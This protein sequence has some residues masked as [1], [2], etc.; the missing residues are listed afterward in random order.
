MLLFSASHLC[1][2]LCRNTSWLARV[3]SQ[4]KL[5]VYCSIARVLGNLYCFSCMALN[6]D[7][8]NYSKPAD[9]QVLNSTLPFLP[10]CW[11]HFYLF[12]FFD[13]DSEWFVGYVLFPT[14]KLSSEP[15]LLC[16][17][18]WRGSTYQLP[19]LENWFSELLVLFI[20]NFYF[21]RALISL[22]RIWLLCILYWLNAVSSS[23][24]WKLLL[25]SMPMI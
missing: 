24:S 1:I 17:L 23:Q 20:Y 16:Y 7:S 19:L 8:D 3:A 13:Q 11:K 21:F 10:L 18:W 22:T 9:F 4:I 5:Q 2:F 15:I 25:F 6:T 14:P 12:N